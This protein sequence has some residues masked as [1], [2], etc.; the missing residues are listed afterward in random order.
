[1]RKIYS[2]VMIVLSCFRSFFSCNKTPD[3]SGKNIHFTSLPSAQTNIN[4]NNTINENDSVN[5]IVNE[6]SY[7]GSGVSV[8]DFNNDHLPDVFFGANQASSGLY[9]NKGNF[10]FDDITDKAGGKWYTVTINLGNLA[11]GTTKLATYGDITKL[12]E[13]RLLLQNPTT[14]DIP[15]KF[16]IDNIRIINNVR[17]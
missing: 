16:A 17:L 7:M 2:A 6:Y 13:L 9:I 10:T 5:L 15:A 14:A 1:M 11:K 12:N 3:P 8:G 4:F